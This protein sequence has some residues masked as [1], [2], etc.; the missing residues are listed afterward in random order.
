LRALPPES[1]SDAVVTVEVPVLANAVGAA[2]LNM[3]QW[4]DDL[5]FRPSRFIRREIAGRFV[6]RVGFK[7]AEE[8]AA[9]AERFGGRVL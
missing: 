5:R 4:L 7:A 3:R 1:R 2:M 9:F 6:V 8:A